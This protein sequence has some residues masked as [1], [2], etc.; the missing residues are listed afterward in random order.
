MTDREAMILSV[1]GNL[2]R[3]DLSPIEKA[4]AFRKLLDSGVFVDKKE[5][6]KS[7]GKDETYVGDVLNTLN[8]DQR[9]IDDILQNRT[10]D[11]VRLLRAIR[12]A[13]KTD[14]LQKSDEQMALYQEFKDKGLSRTKKA[15]IFRTPLQVNRQILLSL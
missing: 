6:S 11:D 13:G 4:M 12:Q 14:K 15:A 8:M 5:L 10:T 9:I 7:L 1:V 3:E 2:Q